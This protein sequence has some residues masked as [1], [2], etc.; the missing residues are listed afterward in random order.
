MAQ[1][2]VHHLNYAEEIRKNFEKRR[3]NKES[4]ILAQS[5]S[6]ISEYFWTA[7]FIEFNPIPYGVYPTHNSIDGVIL[8]LQQL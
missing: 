2:T 1:I 8:T 5:F 3:P 6:S 4:S 7:N